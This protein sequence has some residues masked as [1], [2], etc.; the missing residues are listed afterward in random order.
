MSRSRPSKTNT[1]NPAIGESNC[2]QCDRL[3]EADDMVNCDACELWS[4]YTVALVLMKV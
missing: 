1:T 3:D 2:Q 4:H